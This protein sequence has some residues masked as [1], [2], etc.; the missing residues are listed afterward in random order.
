MLPPSRFSVSTVSSS[1]TVA[2]MEREADAFP[3]NRRDPKAEPEGASSGLL[4]GLRGRPLPD[5][6]KQARR[7][8]V[9]L[10]SGDVTPDVA[11]F[12]RAQ[13]VPMETARAMLVNVPARD[14]AQPVS[15]RQVLGLPANPKVLLAAR[16]TQNPTTKIETNTRF[17]L[18]TP[19]NRTK[20]KERP[21]RAEHA[22]RGDPVDADQRPSGVGNVNNR[23]VTHAQHPDSHV[24]LPIQN[25][26]AAAARNHPALTPAERQKADRDR[27]EWL[28]SLL[29]TNT[30][31]ARE[32]WRNRIGPRYRKTK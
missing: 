27:V 30:A 5:P 2:S 7:R 14:T 18:P 32:A 26:R 19:E 4:A 11:V 15:K 20:L 6:V 17:G 21:V 10:H 23:A 9:V 12:S 16:S 8:V 25:G 28:S 1:G 22:L 13:H 24:D 29:T 3:P 31:S